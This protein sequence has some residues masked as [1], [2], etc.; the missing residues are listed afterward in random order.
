MDQDQ[1]A[2]IQF[3]ESQVYRLQNGL[4]IAAGV[5]AGELAFRGARD[6]LATADIWMSIYG[7]ALM[8]GFAGLVFGLVG[9]GLGLFA[10]PKE[11]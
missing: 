4:S 8:A 1:K 5:I 3:L 6:D 11:H 9:W 2:K 7:Y 10:W